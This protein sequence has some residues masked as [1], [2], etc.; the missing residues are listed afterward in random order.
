[1]G[2]VIPL[3]TDKECEACIVFLKK[4]HEGATQS[5]ESVASPAFQ[6]LSLRELFTEKKAGVK[7]SEKKTAQK[8]PAKIAPSPR[9]SSKRA[10]RKRALWSDDDGGGEGDDAEFVREFQ[11][12]AFKRRQEK[13]QQIKKPKKNLIKKNGKQLKPWDPAKH[14]FVVSVDSYEKDADALVVNAKV[15]A[16]GKAKV[17]R[18][19]VKP[20]V[21]DEISEEHW[22]RMSEYFAKHEMPA[23]FGATRFAKICANHK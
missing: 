16:H 23:S 13:Q 11:K 6:N 15:S 2:E 20:D 8:K 7:G 4:M 1:M 17:H 12:K 18:V 10:V 5:V 9:S 19:L 22:P 21:V 3:L 14:G